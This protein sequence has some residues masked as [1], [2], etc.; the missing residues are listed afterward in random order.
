MSE[1]YHNS[2]FYLLGK[3]YVLWTFK[4][5]Y[6]EF[7]VL[8]KE[9]IIS[10]GPVIYAPNHLNALM[11]ALA[12]LSLP[13][14]KQPKVYLSRADLFYLS[15]VIVNFLRFAKLMPAFRIR[16]GYENLGKNK[17]SFDAAN[18]VLMNDAAMCIMPEGNQG[19]EKNIRPLVKGIFRIA[20][21]AQEVMPA[22]KSVK[23][24]P[25]G[26]DLGDYIKMGKH[27]IVNIGKPLD[28][29][30]YM[31]LYQENPAKAINQIKDDLKT[32]IEGLTL[33]LDSK[34]Y[35]ECWEIATE[36][37]ETSVLK[38]L[39]LPD[40]TVNRFISRKKT[41]E[42]LRKTA[43]NEE[44]IKEL[45][46]LCRSYKSLL[47]KVNLRSSNFEKT[48][49]GTAFQSIRIIDLIISIILFLPGFLLNIIPFKIPSV[50]LK[51]LKIEFNGFFSS[52]Y[53]GFSILSFPVMYL[54]QSILFVLIFSMPW[55]MVILL[56]VLHYITGKFSFIIYKRIKAT[57]AGFRLFKLKKK[58]PEI[59]KQLADFQVRIN[60]LIVSKLSN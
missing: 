16:D 27:M 45:D 31:P 32:A 2:F 54:L 39:Q 18:Q 42:I 60:S 37:T 30:V 38:H 21:N 48:V 1:I 57:L 7:I 23:I 50:F 26:I 10:D 53:Y 55:W 44:E 11:D 20:F 19:T 49:P 36:V 34:E 33:H 56:P 59:Y 12:I 25:V 52:V 14:L 15:P 47:K 29:S 46:Q 8:G 40:N 13:P 3:K 22:G 51:M 41:E 24:V 35:Y 5:Y 6:D 58:K 17:E 9:N 28:V 43:R 4:Q